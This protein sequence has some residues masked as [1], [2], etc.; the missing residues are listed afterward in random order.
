MNVKLLIRKL[1]VFVTCGNKKK[2]EIE[3]K[4]NREQTSDK[5]NV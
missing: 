4:R 5:R 2:K 3:E 1:I